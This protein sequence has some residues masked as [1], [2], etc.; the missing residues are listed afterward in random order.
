MTGALLLDGALLRDKVAVITGASSGIGRAVA[1]EFAQHEAITVLADLDEDGGKE[2]VRQ[3]E[4]AGGRALFRVVDVSSAR[5]VAGLIEETKRR[6][7][8][9]NCAVNNAGIDGAMAPLAESTEE[10]WDRVIGVNLKGIWLCLRYQLPVMLAQGGGSIVNISSVAGLVGVELGLSAYVAAK[11]GVIGLTR[12]AALEYA[13][14]GIRINAVCPGGIRT[15]MLDHALSSGLVTEQQASAR[16][17]MNRL[18]TPHEVARA[19][20]WLCS[21]AASFVTGHAMAVDGGYTAR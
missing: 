21:D 5:D 16:Q 14:T 12:A 6:F 2:T 17:P 10:N 20:A 18:G 4:R 15:A 7:G 9:L 13:T 8:R 1:L 3:V 11:H 19:V